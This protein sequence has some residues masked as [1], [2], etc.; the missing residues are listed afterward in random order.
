[1]TVL[2][3]NIYEYL[4]HNDRVEFNLKSSTHTFKES[5]GNYHS[6]LTTKQQL[7]PLSE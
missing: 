7:Y 3:K 1:M 2:N 6:I 4:Q 5:K